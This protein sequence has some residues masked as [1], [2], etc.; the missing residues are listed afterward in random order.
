MADHRT[1]TAVDPETQAQTTALRMLAA[2]AD[3]LRDRIGLLLQTI[4]QDPVGDR[5]R[6]SMYPW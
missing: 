4:M 3:Q 5:T 1:R 6:G 2:R